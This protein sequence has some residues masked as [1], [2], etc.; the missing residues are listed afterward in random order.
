MLG[1]VSGW[2]GPGYVRMGWCYI[3][4]CCESGLFVYMVGPGICILC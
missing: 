2:P 3:G 1:V 4:V